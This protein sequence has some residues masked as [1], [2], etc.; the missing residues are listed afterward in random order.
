M[1]RPDCAAHFAAWRSDQL[2]SMEGRAMA[3]PDGV[4]HR[5]LE[6]RH[7]ASMEGRAMARPDSTPASKRPIASAMLQWRAEQW[8]GQTRRTEQPAHLSARASMEGRAMARPDLRVLDPGD[9]YYLTLQWRA[10]Q[11]LGQTR[12]LPA[13]NTLPAPRFNGGPSNGSARLIPAHRWKGLL[14]GFNGGPSNGS[15]R[16]RSALGAPAPSGSFNGGPSNGSARRPHR[17]PHHPRAAPASMEGRAMAR[18]DI[19][20]LWL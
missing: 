2:A 4:R 15:A 6:Q 5:Y 3:R 12:C 17:P 7:L 1:A 14:H 18:P 16:R 13:R 11:W 8:L 10:E 19:T 20:P 9:S